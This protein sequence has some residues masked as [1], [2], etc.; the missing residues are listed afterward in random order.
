MEGAEMPRKRGRAR[1]TTRRTRTDPA[2]RERALDALS[3]MRSDG[4]SLKRAARWAHTTP[5]TVRKYV[6]QAL[7]KTA[8][9]RY[10]ATPSDRL[11]RYIRFLT[12][13][14]IVGIRVR[15]SKA[16]SRVA[17]H[18]AAVKH[19]LLTGETEALAEF[20]G[21]S[22]RA[23]GVTYPFITDPKTLERIDAARE[24]SFERLYTQRG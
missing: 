23:G 22:I 7:V 12:K 18:W 15:G 20:R 9:G 14:G 19:Y 24:T 2:A 4:L 8:G 1:K 16:A 6:G 11:T 17:R 5:E 3:R 21:R 13:D 10:A